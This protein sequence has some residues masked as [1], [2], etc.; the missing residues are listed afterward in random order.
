MNANRTK[1]LLST[2]QCLNHVFLLEDLK[3]TSV[4]KTSF[5]IWTDM[6][7][8]RFERYGELAKDRALKQNSKCIN[9]NSSWRSLGRLGNFQKLAHNCLEM[10]CT[11]YVLDDLTSCGQST[12]LR[13]QSQNALRHV[14]NDWQG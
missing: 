6:L 11:W 14:T 3:I 7:K 4:V 13:D 12:S 10:L 5:T 9:I 2:E 1:L 8:K